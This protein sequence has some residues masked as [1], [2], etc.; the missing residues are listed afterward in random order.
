MIFVIAYG[1][2]FTNII[3]SFIFIKLVS[4][5]NTFKR[6]EDLY[7]GNGTSVKEAPQRYCTIEQGEPHKYFLYNQQ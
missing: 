3:T 5:A 2:Y 7:P 1:F 4:I 6:M